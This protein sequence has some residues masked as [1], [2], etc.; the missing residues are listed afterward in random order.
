MP[1]ITALLHARNDALRLGR[2][3]ETLRPCDEILVLDHGSADRTRELAREYG[4]TVVHASG[5]DSPAV[6]LRVARYSW[7]LCLL[8]SEALSEALEASLFEWK[9]HTADQV[10][11]VPACSFAVRDETV[12][13][14][15]DAGEV[16]RL[17]PRS[18][19]HW[20]GALPALHLAARRL[21]G[22]LLRFRTS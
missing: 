15:I 4:A 9:L 3:L 20:E 14:W 21:P 18:W 8:P 17:V 22:H 1:P 12:D 10:R 7:V 16:T 2:A 11:D 5:A 6:Y 13:G 19:V